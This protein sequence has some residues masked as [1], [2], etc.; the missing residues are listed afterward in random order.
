MT[1][2]CRQLRRAFLGFAFACS[3]GSG[4]A[5]VDGDVAVDARPVDA[6]APPDASRPEP[7]TGPVDRTA[8]ELALEPVRSQTT[9]RQ[10]RLA[11][12]ATDDGQVSVRVEDGTRDMDAEV[13]DS[14]AFA[15]TLRLRPGPNTLR[16]VAEDDAGNVSDVQVEVY[17]G[18][19]VSVGNSQSV[20][21][22]GDARLTWGRNE[23]GQLGN[24]T[25][26]GSAYGDDPE[27]AELPARYSEARAGVVS[28]VTRQTFMLALH[29]DGRVDAWGSN[30]EGQ[31]GYDTVADCGSRSDT[32]CSRSAGTVPGLSDVVAIEAG[33]DHGLALHAD[34]TI[35][36]W[37]S[38]ALGQLAR[39]EGAAT[40]AARITALTNVVELAAGVDSTYALDSSGSV[41]AFGGNRNGQLAIGR[42]DTERHPAPTRV[43]GLSE[44]RAITSANRTA[45]ALLADGRLMG[46][47]Q[48]NAG[49][50]GNG[51]DTGEDVTEPAFVLTGSGEPLEDVVA[52]AADGFVAVAQD[53][54]GQLYAW[55]L[56]ALG[57][58][59]QGLAGDGEPDL[60]NRFSASEVAIDDADRAAFDVVEFEVGAGGPVLALTRAGNL[61][62][63]GWSF[64]GSLG[65]EGALDAWAYSSPLLVV[66]AE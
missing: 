19:R 5:P 15:A 57:Q 39:P 37:G 25:L 4:T 32:P 12:T 38:D 58:L 11:G 21:L 1:W 13:D 9:G 64:R 16:V 24:G 34:G 60:E 46:W 8:P 7:E 26:Q 61:F 10:L 50:V 47:G 22:Q 35:S 36:G 53:R 17:Y 66:A 62:G 48:N 44:V 14:G 23:L 29:E 31:L 55:G 49:Q 20:F 3:S 2:L 33:Y 30:D 65:L 41:W 18:R 45:Y 54:E 63:W 27:T 40:T 52:V 42:A 56:G 59:G 43:A 6:S 28:V 51:D